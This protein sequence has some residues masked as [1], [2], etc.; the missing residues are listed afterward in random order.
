[1]K[2]MV[3]MIVIRICNREAIKK[4]VGVRTFSRKKIARNIDWKTT[5]RTSSW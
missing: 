5:L 3:P 1:M 4:R 2:G